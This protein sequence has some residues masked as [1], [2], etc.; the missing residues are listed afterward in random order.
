M[1]PEGIHPN[2]VWE[3]GVTDGD[4]PAH[5]F[6]EAL[7]SEVTEDGCRVDQDVPAVL[8]MG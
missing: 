4:V 8:G 3:L 7:A 6:R 5:T 1:P 2:V